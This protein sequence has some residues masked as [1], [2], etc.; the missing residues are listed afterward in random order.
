MQTTRPPS[1]PAPTPPPVTVNEGSRHNSSDNGS[2]LLNPCFST[3]GCLLDTTF[4]ATPPHQ[5]R[6]VISDTS[7]TPLLLTTASEARWRRRK[8]LSNSNIEGQKRVSRD[9][10]LKVSV[11]EEVH[12]VDVSWL[13][14]PKQ[15]YSMNM[16]QLWK[17]RQT[18]T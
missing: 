7:L 1:R 4:A 2:G 3:D 12:G 17:R 16:T 10:V 8:N 6:G 9:L 13:H 5:R 14:R 18:D 15:G 11:M